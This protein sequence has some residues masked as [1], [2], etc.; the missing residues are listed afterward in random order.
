L[1]ASGGYDYSYVDLELLARR[2]LRTELADLKARA[3][4]LG[5]QARR[6]AGRG[7]VTAVTFPE[8]E[9]DASSAVLETAVR[10]AGEEVERLRERVDGLFTQALLAGIAAPAAE[11]TTGEERT[12][13][14]RPAGTVTEPAV[15]APELLRV[16]DEA[17][18]R[19]ERLLREEGRR[20]EPG[21]LGPLTGL[22]GEIGG[23]TRVEQVR[24]AAA[25]FERRLAASIENRVHREE[26]A[27]TR[28]RLHVLVDQLPAARRAPL[29]AAVESETRLPALE[30]LGE[31][32]GAAVT[33]ADRAAAPQAV[34][35]VAAEALAAIGCEVGAGFATALATEGESVVALDGERWPADR[36]ALLLRMDLHGGGPQ[37][38]RAAR[39]RG[40]RHRPAA[41]LR[42][43]PARPAARGDGRRRRPPPRGAP[44]RT[45]TPPDAG[46]RRRPV[47]R[48]RPAHR[49]CE[50]AQAQDETGDRRPRA[51]GAPP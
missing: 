21:D 11:Q 37:R 19:A 33:E 43:R 10:Q 14:A 44:A 1:S 48:R 20:C 13:D 46:R 41:V 30:E 47:A 50:R 28:A 16:R 5:D 45:G 42:G 23:T 32:V 9:E 39:R 17:V 22:L 40:R 24:R 34:A 12:G 51:Q 4:I 8:P 6:T 2:R 3:E 18:A 35:A 29:H 38:E 36:Y 26:V 7:A 15:R 25:E 27:R 49:A 31:L